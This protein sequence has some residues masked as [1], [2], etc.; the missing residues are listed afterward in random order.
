MPAFV[1]ASISTSCTSSGDALRP[2]LRE[3]VGGEQ[4]C[5][6]ALLLADAGDQ[7]VRCGIGQLVEAAL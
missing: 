7:C 1:M 5:F 4:R 6:V 2:S 3:Q